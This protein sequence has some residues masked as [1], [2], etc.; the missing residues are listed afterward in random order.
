MPT[1]KEMV[2]YMKSRCQSDKKWHN[3]QFEATTHN[4]NA[5]CNHLDQ[6]EK[7]GHKCVQPIASRYLDK[8]ADG[9]RNNTH[10]Y[11]INLP[12][13]EY[14]KK[15]TLILT[16]VGFYNQMLFAIATLTAREELKDE[17][18]EELKS[19]G[20]KQEKSFKKEYVAMCEANAKLKEK[21]KKAN[22]EL[23]ELRKVKK[24]R[25]YIKKLEQQLFDAEV[26]LLSK[27]AD[28]LAL[29]PAYS[30]N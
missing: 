24:E 17:E 21:L 4:L 22:I 19:S 10:I 20:S 26:R 23:D 16:D 6:Y 2:E 18:L 15:P 30:V 11:P 13:K 3:E 7:V 29:P 5:A 28:D 1:F 12:Y 8:W 27:Q 9:W 14:S 25:K